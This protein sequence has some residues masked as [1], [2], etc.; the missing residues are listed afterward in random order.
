MRQVYSVG[1]IQ[2]VAVDFSFSSFTERHEASFKLLPDFQLMT[3]YLGGQA[4]GVREFEM[5]HRPDQLIS[6]L[7]I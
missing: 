5:R 2:I 1:R 6:I 3:S 7:L 4:E